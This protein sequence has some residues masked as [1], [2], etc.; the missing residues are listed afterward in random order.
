MPK[1]YNTS[2]R[3]L[4]FRLRKFKPILEEHLKKEFEKHEKE[5]V[6]LIRD[7]LYAGLDGYEEP[8]EPPYAMR[9]K[10]RKLKKGQPI[11]R[12]TLKDTGRFYESL[13]IQFDASGFRIVS[14]ESKAQ[15]LLKKYGPDV[16]RL[17]NENLNEVIR[18]YIRPSLT[19]KLKE[20][21]HG[22]A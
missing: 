18:Q 13:R 12:V 14:D 5:I 21:L 17:M 4:E 8:I 20:Y 6:D 10:K 15:F 19:K 2:L 7:Q 3:N 9:T 1:Y 22:R 11:D 16:L